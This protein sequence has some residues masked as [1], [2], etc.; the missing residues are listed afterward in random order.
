MSNPLPS[1]LGAVT[2]LDDGAEAPRPR[3]ADEATVAGDEPAADLFIMH[4]GIGVCGGTA[5]HDGGTLH[6]RFLERV[7]AAASLTSPCVGPAQ[8]SIRAG[9]KVRSLSKHSFKRATIYYVSSQQHHTQ[10]WTAALK[11][12]DKAVKAYVA[13]C[14][15][16]YPRKE[17]LDAGEIYE[18][19]LEQWEAGRLPRGHPCM[20]NAPGGA[21]A[22][23]F[24]TTDD[25]WEIQKHVRGIYLTKL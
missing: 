15:A 5:S 9:E 4:P 2:V 11:P 7:Q 3:R 23:T 10:T 13:R 21:A 17:W 20:P 14:K 16:D 12:S 1:D 22:D 19:W 18:N 24:P 6:T 8:V 25:A